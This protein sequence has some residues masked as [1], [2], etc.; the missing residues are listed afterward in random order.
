MCTFKGCDK[1][2]AH[3]GFAVD[4]LNKY[5][6]ISS[7]FEMFGQ[8]LYGACAECI[9]TLVRSTAI[10]KGYI[11]DA[12]PAAKGAEMRRPGQAPK[13]DQVVHYPTSYDARVLRLF[14]IE[15]S[16]REKPVSIPQDNR[17]EWYVPRQQ[18]QPKENTRLML[19]HYLRNQGIDP[20]K[21]GNW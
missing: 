17:R 4:C 14:E 10:R 5:G 8:G 13:V 3:K 21:V 19:W 11:S 2:A 1:P 9:G 7:K 6:M 18:E 15:Q 16:L 12:S 20:L